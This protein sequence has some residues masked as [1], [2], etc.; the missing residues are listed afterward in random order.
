VPVKYAA[1]Y[2]Y[3]TRLTFSSLPL[4]V[5]NQPAFGRE[6]FQHEIKTLA[7]GIAY[8]DLYHMNTQSGTQWDGFRSVLTF[9]EQ[10]TSR[11]TIY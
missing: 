10:L 11:L 2:E 4:N 8:D 5:P 9:S 3:Y 6:T 1:Q 7:E